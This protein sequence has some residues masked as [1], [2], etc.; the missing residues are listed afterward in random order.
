MTLRSASSLLSPAPTRTVVAA[1]RYIG[2]R[3]CISFSRAA[4]GS[5]CWAS[6]GRL[7]ISTSLDCSLATI[8][9]A[10]QPRTERKENKQMA[11]DS[12]FANACHE[13]HAPLTVMLRYT[14]TP[15]FKYSQLSSRITAPPPVA[16]TS[17]DCVES[18]HDK[19]R[20]QS[21]CVNQRHNRNPTSTAPGSRHP[22]CFSASCSACRKN[23]SLP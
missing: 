15:L 3:A 7:L 4:C 10:C 22:T 9:A 21:R 14:T 12:E 11:D 16:M 8:S 18:C 5:A 19:T 13:S 17:L 20:T 23:C 6:K 1:F 2:A